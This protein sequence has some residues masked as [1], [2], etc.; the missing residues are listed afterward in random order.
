M[1][2]GQFKINDKVTVAKD[3]W[4]RILGSNS[5]ARVQQ[6]RDGRLI[7]YR[8]IG[9]GEFPIDNVSANTLIVD[10]ESEIFVAINACNLRNSVAHVN[11][12]FMFGNHDV[13]AQLSDESKKAVL[14]AR[15]GIKQ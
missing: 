14:E 7:E 12:C 15:L 8:V 9:H 6:C 3:A 11:V 4:S 1:N 13:T 5:T 10:P 2:V